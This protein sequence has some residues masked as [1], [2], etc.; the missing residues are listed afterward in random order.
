MERNGIKESFDIAV[1][2][3]GPAGATAAALCAKRGYSVAVLERDRGSREKLCGEFISPETVSYLARLGCVESFH[4]AHPAAITRVH[5]R[6]GSSVIRVPFTGTGYGL[7]RRALDGLLLRLASES[8]AVLLRGWRALSIDATEKRQYDTSG[9]NTGGGC[10]IHGMAGG[11]KWTIIARLVIGAFGMKT[12]GARMLSNGRSGRAGSVAFKTHINGGT[13]DGSIRMFFFRDGYV[14]IAD[15][16]GGKTN[17]CGIAGSD[18]LG[19]AG[20]SIGRLLNDF[21]QEQPAFRRWYDRIPEDAEFIGA[22]GL[23]FG[24]YGRT[25]DAF[26]RI[27]D[28]VGSVHP[29]CGDGNAMAIRSAFLLEPVLDGFFT[30]RHSFS[31]MSMF[32]ARVWK[33]EFARR[34]RISGAI[35]S[36]LRSRMLPPLVFMLLRR[37]PGLLQP[38][39]RMTRGDIE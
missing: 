29:F 3:G 30:G 38:V 27:G 8:G 39:I 16:E 11:E 12:G 26:L 10:T 24:V 7:S 17:L 25:R 4:A 22:A 19:R 20:G 31:D 35:D 36:I 18:T 21:A 28:A 6:R 14:G 37:Y 5:L 9:G 23:R 34:I 33:K 2:G 1:I 32:Y 13:G 15:I